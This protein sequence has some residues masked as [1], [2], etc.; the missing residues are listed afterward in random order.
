MK[1][2]WQVVFWLWNNVTALNTDYSPPPF[3]SKKL[4]IIH[5]NWASYLQIWD[6]T[7]ASIIKE[8][9]LGKEAGSGGR[10]IGF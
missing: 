4:L 8:K 9:S 1:H 7:G 2:L 6:S 5:I 3:P 10:F